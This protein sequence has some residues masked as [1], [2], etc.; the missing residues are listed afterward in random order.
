M[1][2]AVKVVKSI[3]GYEPGE[4][5]DAATFGDQLERLVRKGCLEPL[6][7]LKLPGK[8]PDA[9][10]LH[11][12]IELLTERIGSIEKDRDDWKAKAIA[13]SGDLEKV[14]AALRDLEAE[15]GKLKAT[16]AQTPTPAT[17]VDEWADAGPP[18]PIQTPAK[19]K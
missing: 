14:K 10:D 4:I 11:A 1:G 8:P 6:D 13:A 3:T 12:E 15:Y 16:Q 2:V 7:D 5:H 9:A 19:K 17:V 18:K